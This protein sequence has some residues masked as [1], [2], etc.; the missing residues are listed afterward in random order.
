MLASA[1]FFPTSEEYLEWV[2]SSP[3]D[4]LS[5]LRAPSCERSTGE[6]SLGFPAVFAP[7]FPTRWLL[8][9]CSRGL[10]SPL[11]LRNLWP[12][13]HTSSERSLASPVLCPSDNAWLLHLPLQAD[14]WSESPGELITADFWVTHQNQNYWGEVQEAKLFFQLYWGIT[15]K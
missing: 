5:S 4:V 7:L 3:V 13:P 8:S 12:S 1:P 10:T 11:S 9:W 2:C 14:C 15:D 6:F